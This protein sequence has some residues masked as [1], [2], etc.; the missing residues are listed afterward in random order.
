MIRLE[1]INLV[2]SDIEKVLSFYRAA[3]PHWRVRGKGTAKWYGKDRQWVHFG[4]D[5]NYLTLNDDGEGHNRNLEGH[6]VGLAH[7]AFV[8]NDLDAMNERLA[9]A[10]FN[11]AKQGAQDPYRKNVYYLDPAGFEVEF[12]QYFSDLPHQRN[13]YA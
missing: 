2:V 4:D 3:F 9:L 6:Q 12:V 10:G 1:H 5:E 7:F 8:I 13:L 11:I